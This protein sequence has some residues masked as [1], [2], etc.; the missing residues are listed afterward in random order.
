MAAATSSINSTSADAL[1]ANGPGSLAGVMLARGITSVAINQ[2]QSSTV[3]FYLAPYQ[4]GVAG[5]LTQP[6][7]SS[8][9]RIWASPITEWNSEWVGDHILLAQKASG[10]VQGSAYD[11]SQKGALTPLISNVPG[12]FVRENAA[13]HAILYST[14]ASDNSPKLS[15]R[16][17]DGTVIDLP[18]T[19]FADK[20]LWST[21][22]SVTVFCAVPHL[23]S[24][25]GTLPDA[26]YR[27]EMHFADAWWKF[28]TV[29]GAVDEVYDP[30]QASHSLDILDPVMSSDGA[31]L[32][33]INAT[34]GSAWILRINP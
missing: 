21:H 11:L 4:S 15:V 8:L 7:G 13:T 16:N 20:C 31:Y 2:N 3:V 23:I 10:N 33:F 14:V 28:N 26:W 25:H 29:T 27:G 5:F 24:A 34:D 22:D 9:T 32:G 30:Q 1:A 18:F 17:P 19:T 6:N 12:L